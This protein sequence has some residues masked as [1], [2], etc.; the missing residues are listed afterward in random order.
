MFCCPHCS[1]LL[2]ILNNIVKPE[3]GVTMSMLNNIVDNIEQRAE[4]QIVFNLPPGKIS[5]VFKPSSKC[6]KV[7]LSQ[8]KIRMNRYF[9][10]KKA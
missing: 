4:L 6:S 1:R 2:R 3:S 8:L 9:F 10:R 7:G 5:K